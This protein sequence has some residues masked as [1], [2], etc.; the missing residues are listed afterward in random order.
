MAEAA[1]HQFV[2]LQACTLLAGAQQM[3]E[4]LH[5]GLGYRQRSAREHGIK[6][7]LHLQV[8]S[9]DHKLLLWQCLPMAPS[10]P[11]KAWAPDTDCLQLTILSQV[12]C[13]I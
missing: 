12:F 11:E 3:L 7:Q 9:T 8:R 10:K 13:L 1:L 2:K 4:V 6:P 5:L